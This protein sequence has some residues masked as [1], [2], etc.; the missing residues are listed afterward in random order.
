MLFCYGYIF[1]ARFVWYICP[2]FIYYIYMHMCQSQC[3]VQGIFVNLY[4][5]IREKRYKGK[6]VF[7]FV[8]T[9]KNVNDLYPPTPNFL[10]SWLKRRTL[11]KLTSS[12]SSLT[13]QTSDIYTLF[14]P[15]NKAVTVCNSKI[16]KYFIAWFQYAFQSSNKMFIMLLWIHFLAVVTNYIIHRLLPVLFTHFHVKYLY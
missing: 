12:G 14:I 16:I 10:L 9:I 2:F 6:T 5:C 8:E 1:F 11:G 4:H 3:F 13:H 7:I 15:K